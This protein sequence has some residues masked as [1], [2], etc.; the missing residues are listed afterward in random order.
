MLSAFLSV[1]GLIFDDFILN[2]TFAQSKT[3]SKDAR[4]PKTP[5][6]T[7][8]K[9]DS[10]SI[11]NEQHTGHQ[12]IDF[13]DTRLDNKAFGKGSH[14]LW[15]GK[16]LAHLH[17][18]TPISFSVQKGSDHLK[19][20]QKTDGLVV[21]KPP[22][23][24]L[25]TKHT[26]VSITNP[27]FNHTLFIDT[28][29]KRLLTPLKCSQ[30]S[31]SGTKIHRGFYR[32]FSLL[33]DVKGIA[34]S[35][36]VLIREVFIVVPLPITERQISFRAFGILK[37]RTPE[38]EQIRS[39]AGNLLFRSAEA[40]FLVTQVRRSVKN[41][42]ALFLAK[43]L[44]RL[45]WI[46]HDHPIMLENVKS[47]NLSKRFRNTC[48]GTTTI[49]R[50]V[51]K[52][53]KTND[54]VQMANRELRYF[55]YTKAKQIKFTSRQDAKLPSSSAVNPPLAIHYHHP[56]IYWFSRKRK[57]SPFL[58]QFAKF[59][60]NMVYHKTFAT[61]KVSR[62]YHVPGVI[63]LIRHYLLEVSDARSKEDE[64]H[65]LAIDVVV[66]STLLSLI[67]VESNTS[68][69]QSNSYPKGLV[70]IFQR[71]CVVDV[72]P[73]NLI[74]MDL[75][76]LKKCR[77]I[78]RNSWRFGLNFRLLSE[79]TVKRRKSVIHKG[80][81]LTQNSMVKIF[82][83]VCTPDL[84]DLLTQTV[85]SAM[86]SVQLTSHLSIASYQISQMHGI[87]LAL[88]TRG[89]IPQ[90]S[91]FEVAKAKIRTSSQRILNDLSKSIG[92][93]LCI[94]ALKTIR[95]KNVFTVPANRF[96]YRTLHN[97]LV[98]SKPRID[99]LKA[100]TSK[101]HEVIK[102]SSFRAVLYNPF[103]PS[104]RQNKYN[105]TSLRAATA[106]VTHHY[107]HGHI[108]LSNVLRV[109]PHSSTV[110]QKLNA[111]R[112]IVIGPVFATVGVAYLTEIR[113]S[114]ALGYSNQTPFPLM[115]TFSKIKVFDSMHSTSLALIRP[116]LHKLKFELSKPTQIQ[117]S[118]RA[119][120]TIHKTVNTS[121]SI[122]RLKW[123]GSYKG[124]VVYEWIFTL[125][126]TTATK[127]ETKLAILSTKT[128]AKFSHTSRFIGEVNIKRFSFEHT[129]LSIYRSKKGM[130]LSMV[131]PHLVCDQ[132]SNYS[133][134]PKHCTI[135]VASKSTKNIFHNECTIVEEKKI[136]SFSATVLT[137]IS[138][139]NSEENFLPLLKK[140]VV[141]AVTVN[142]IQSVIGF[143]R[144]N[145]LALEPSSM[146]K[147]LRWPINKSGYNILKSKKTVLSVYSTLRN[148][149][150]SPVK[151]TSLHMIRL[152]FSRGFTILLLK[153]M[154]TA[155]FSEQHKML[156]LMKYASSVRY[157]PSHTNTL[158]I[159]SKPMTESYFVRERTW[160]IRHTKTIMTGG[161]KGIA[162]EMVMFLDKIR[163][164][165]GQ[166]VKIKQYKAFLEAAVHPSSCGNCNRIM[167]N[168]LMQT[169]Y[170]YCPI[171]QRNGLVKRS[172]SNHEFCIHGIYG[173]YFWYA[174]TTNY[175][176]IWRFMGDVIDPT[177]FIHYYNFRFTN[178][179]PFRP[180][181]PK[182]SFDPQTFFSQP[183]QI[184]KLL[185]PD[186]RTFPLTFEWFHECV[187][188]KII[189]M[190]IPPIRITFEEIS[191]HSFSLLSG[192]NPPPRSLFLLYERNSPVLSSLGQSYNLIS[193]QPP[194]LIKTMTPR[195]V[196]YSRYRDDILL[197]QTLLFSV[198]TSSTYSISTG[199][200]VEYILPY[201]QTLTWRTKR[202]QRVTF[203]STERL[204]YRTIPMYREMRTSKFKKLIDTIA[205]PK[206][207]YTVSMLRTTKFIFNT[208][209][210]Y[211]TF[212]ISSRATTI[213][214]FPHI[215]Y[216]SIF[217]IKI[218]LHLITQDQIE[219]APTS[220]LL[221][222]TSP[223][224]LQ[225]SM[226][227]F[228]GQLSYPHDRVHF[229]MYVHI[230]SLTQPSMFY[231]DG[232]SFLRQND[233][234]IM[235]VLRKMT[236]KRD[237]MKGN[238]G[239]FKVS[240]ITKE[241]LMKLD[242][243]ILNPPKFNSIFDIILSN[244]HLQTMTRKEI[245]SSTKKKFLLQKPKEPF[246]KELTFAVPWFWI[247]TFHIGNM[248]VFQIR[249][250]SVSLIKDDSDFNNVKYIEY[251]DILLF[252]RF[253]TEKGHKVMRFHR[254]VIFDVEVD[255]KLSSWTNRNHL[256][257]YK[258][259]SMQN[260]LITSSVTNS[261][262]AR[263]RI[264]KDD[265]LARTITW[266]YIGQR[267]RMYQNSEQSIKQY[268]FTQLMV[269]SEIQEKHTK[270]KFIATTDNDLKWVR[271]IRRRWV[272]LSTDFA[273]SQSTFAVG[274]LFVKFQNRFAIEYHGG[275]VKTR[276]EALLS[277]SLSVE[278]IQIKK[279]EIQL[280]DVWMFKSQHVAIVKHSM[281]WL[282]DRQSVLSR[283]IDYNRW[284]V[285]RKQSATFSVKGSMSHLIT[286][287][288]KKTMVFVGTGITGDHERLFQKLL[289]SEKHLTSVLVT[290]MVFSFERKMIVSRYKYELQ[291]KLI[292]FLGRKL[293]ME[294]LKLSR[295][296]NYS[297]ISVKGSARPKLTMQRFSF[298]TFAEQRMQ[299][300]GITHY[301]RHEAEVYL[302]AVI[303]VV[304]YEDLSSSITT[305]IWRHG[306]TSF[307]VENIHT[308]HL[309]MDI[310][311]ANVTNTDFFKFIGAGHQT[312][313]H[314][315]SGPA[316]MK[317]TQ[318]GSSTGILH[319]ITFLR[320]KEWNT[321]VFKK[322]GVIHFQAMR[323]S[324]RFTQEAISVGTVTAVERKHALQSFHWHS[325]GSYLMISLRSLGVSERKSIFKLVKKNDIAFIIKV[326][327][328]NSFQA[329][330]K[331]HRS[332]MDHAVGFIYSSVHSP[333]TTLYHQDLLD[334]KQYA[335]KSL[336]SVILAHEMIIHT[337]RKTT[338]RTDQKFTGN[339]IA[340]NQKKEVSIIRRNQ[341]KLIASVLSVNQGSARSWKRNKHLF[342]YKVLHS[343]VIFH[344]NLVKTQ[345][346]L[347]SIRHIRMKTSFAKDHKSNYHSFLFNQD[348]TGFRYSEKVYRKSMK[349]L[350][351]KFLLGKPKIHLDVHL[352]TVEIFSYRDIIRTE[353][354][355][356]KG[357]TASATYIAIYKFSYF[358]HQEY[359][360]KFLVQRSKTIKRHV[361]TKIE[362]R[363]VA[364]STVFVLQDHYTNDLA[365]H[366]NSKFLPYHT[367]LLT[368]RANR[369][370]SILTRPY[371]SNRSARVY[372]FISSSVFRGDIQDQL[373]KVNRK[374][375]KR[376]VVTVVISKRKRARMFTNR[377]YMVRVYTLDRKMDARNGLLHIER[378]YRPLGPVQYYVSVVRGIQTNQFAN[379]TSYKAIPFVS[380]EL[381]MIISEY[382]YH[383]FVYPQS[384]IT[385]LGSR[386]EPRVHIIFRTSLLHKS[387]KPVVNDV[388]WMFH[389]IHQ[390]YKIQ[391]MKL[392]IITNVVHHLAT[393]PIQKCSIVNIAFTLKYFTK[394]YAENVYAYNGSYKVFLRS[395][396]KFSQSSRIWKSP[397][398]IAFVS[399]KNSHNNFG[400]TKTLNERP[401]SVQFEQTQEQLPTLIYVSDFTWMWIP[402]T[403]I[404]TIPSIIRKHLKSSI[405]TPVI[406]DS[407]EHLQM[408]LKPYL[409]AHTPKLIKSKLIVIG[410]VRSAINIA[411]TT[412][413]EDSFGKKVL[414]M[415]YIKQHSAMTVKP[416]VVGTSRSRLSVDPLSCSEAS[417]PKLLTHKVFF[418][419]S[420]EDFC[421]MQRRLRSALAKALK[422]H[423]EKKTSR[424]K[425]LRIIGMNVRKNSIHC[426]ADL[427][428][429]RLS[430]S[431]DGSN[432]ITSFVRIR[433]QPTISSN[434]AHKTAL[435]YQTLMNSL[436]TE[437]KTLFY[438]VS[439]SPSHLTLSNSIKTVAEADDTLFLSKCMTTLLTRYDSPSVKTLQMTEMLYVPSHDDTGTHREGENVLHAVARP[440][441]KHAMIYIRGRVPHSD[442]DRAA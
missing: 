356:K 37:L 91:I 90:P 192:R 146:L 271:F 227:T 16:G 49:L 330:T 241:E 303:Q 105:N 230:P 189:V 408:K 215:N 319:T 8:L 205:L 144:T 393:S 214:V 226:I 394:R 130:V 73:K 191:Q 412:Y 267:K 278:K 54:V 66:R 114:E 2:I 165:S 157:P 171:S 310:S 352:S 211:R 187:H 134:T 158:K 45:Q 102:L 124:Y 396:P 403:S 398:V 177:F 68:K 414:R 204:I 180:Y 263:F 251:R 202:H 61:D 168:D 207:S 116:N 296:S 239:D 287:K 399:F 349:R 81:Y 425:A 297:Q 373:A 7:S 344:I 162:E 224:E 343:R 350:R 332:I 386:T 6:D 375:A 329:A 51:L 133:K 277:Y 290:T 406:L 185:D 252:Y 240:K 249:R 392:P 416:Q 333:T 39:L 112:N 60:L 155:A 291:H 95:L 387:D 98:I 434:Y 132:D 196:L 44:S 364:S 372:V 259:Y 4:S 323:T 26:S 347:L 363:V 72:I 245:T 270:D 328:K 113:V 178:G 163:V 305:R 19:N 361:L 244:D 436:A 311:I 377:A 367:A 268:L 143:S 253:S 65:Y 218:K 243:D 407:S 183:Q 324:T 234:I 260:S 304:S 417:P 238:V 280:V 70:N 388:K 325:P 371:T 411:Y 115:Q 217:I 75:K 123:M 5:T 43:G 58:L 206:P 153:T 336:Y 221:A 219:D 389:D 182:V 127:Q 400:I 129:S 141:T 314:T 20:T 11:K 47:H 42:G 440:H 342:T 152:A 437:P 265:M 101:R 233:V 258:T 77:P 302:N 391:L 312:K 201:I 52:I 339:F 22:N 376:F 169:D 404:S 97:I 285:K 197:V 257:W 156:I 173:P 190:Q 27:A 119:L 103:V 269:S 100:S 216:E 250:T 15:K 354:H 209:S 235:T 337:G 422:H 86:H 145:T 33:I 24:V 111:W 166:G 175:F 17:A 82:Y 104:E 109:I 309:L 433:K 126:Q 213:Q 179:L 272:N 154:H 36:M 360:G 30:I 200:V 338:L 198:V 107:I 92:S 21:E 228:R 18:D 282:M 188:I 397:K 138:R 351:P 71:I 369:G 334:S 395:F 222:I 181:D 203:A 176:V 247:P 193:M 413:D 359:K 362:S 9:F 276:A 31:I 34:T 84:E 160:D 423:R 421:L 355:E 293:F 308:F 390:K 383:T 321:H 23:F 432:G 93:T 370:G 76:N 137:K 136:I 431:N 40:A 12:P 353:S 428:T 365:L 184:D 128:E 108:H 210:D 306:K 232:F 281:K 94:S 248:R 147:E 298:R 28:N 322:Y 261:N 172:M 424:T 150:P 99:I 1:C 62:S 273:S 48:Y 32:S 151:R 380:S 385:V 10:N 120:I 170:N 208:E 442:G 255:R 78:F 225:P 266:L 264:H 316:L 131:L 110:Q 357:F 64:S 164:Q 56:V 229:G 301:K 139:L 274:T 410:E 29:T 418:T 85:F 284:Y 419:S 256:L 167:I 96:P 87:I 195:L 313:V 441:L 38:F 340:V 63:F 292:Y 327:S 295:K 236:S 331:A 335:V 315:V 317:M 275:G 374:I 288:T 254:I 142:T 57:D 122:V 242:D 118:R 79:M 345:S 379:G 283:S 326:F 140:E 80:I 358:D 435:L 409:K 174:P 46:A 402:N 125:S 148:R 348:L 299:V 430:G 199:L 405:H 438:K 50:V 286:Q 401:S 368:T 55:V 35:Y 121:H 231:M 3:T 378:I 220:R 186:F 14:I 88:K 427:T 381:Y 246:I 135:F 59:D 366:R 89:R 194:Q 13:S 420:F 67:A 320:S 382:G 212:G 41:P 346:K 83:S 318:H 74:K 237:V 53:R 262:M 69:H 300:V 106:L 161:L 307:T 289:L 341:Q 429:Y 117:I 159:T 279:F 439:G 25:T 384:T 415:I 426:D 149:V 223:D 294:K